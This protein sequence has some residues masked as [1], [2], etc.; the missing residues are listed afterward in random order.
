MVGI[1]SIFD[2]SPA[3]ARGKSFEL[4][5]DIDIRVR[6]RRENLRLPSAGGIA[7]KHP[8]SYRQRYEGTP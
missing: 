5:S 6:G 2:K 3:F 7:A 1:E 4:Q 8:T